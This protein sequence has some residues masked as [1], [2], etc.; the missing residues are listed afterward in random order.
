[1]NKKII[2]ISAGRSDYDRY[3][4]I[5]KGLNKKKKIKIYLFL[6]KAHQD[7]KFGNTYSFIDKDFSIIKNKYTNNDFRKNMTES[8]CD[9]LSFLVKKIKKIN[10]NLLVVLGDRFEMLIGPISVIPNNTPIVHFFGG[11]VTEGAIDEQVRHAITKMSHLHFVATQSYKERLI[12]LGEEK[13]RIK[14]IGVHSLDIFKKKSNKTKKKLNKYFKFDFN[15]PYCLVTFHPVTL[16]LNRIRNQL[17]NLLY[18]LKKSN[19]NIAFT[20]PNADPKNEIIIESYKKNFNDKNKYLFIKNCGNENY[21]SIMKNCLFVIGNSSSG[22][23]EAASLKIPSINIG[24]RQNGKLK[25][26]NVIDSDYSIKKILIAIKKAQS[27][28][29][30]KEIK[31]LKNPYQSKLSVSKVVDTLVKLKINDKLLRKKFIKY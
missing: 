11:A 4:P 31:K 15:K 27:P 30:K 28:K 5:L 29:F 6:T 8:F 2:V 3:Y 19:L 1:M 13:W 18:C 10:P 17:K 24:T 14:N 12:Q 25:P 7:E 21:A 22:L 26:T 16:E 20:Y 23:V 9:D